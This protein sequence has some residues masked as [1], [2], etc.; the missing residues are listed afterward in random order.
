MKREREEDRGLARI[1]K[2]QKSA[3]PEP[4]ATPNIPVAPPP[5]AVN[6]NN[7]HLPL[8]LGGV[9][10]C[11]VDP[12]TR[13][14]NTTHPDKTMREL[15]I[16]NTTEACDSNVLK[17]F[18]NAAMTRVGLTLPN[19]PQFNNGQPICVVRCAPKFAFAQARSEVEAA[20][21]LNLTNIPFMGQ[22]LKITRPSK[23][24]GVK[25]KHGTWQELTGV[26]DANAP[27]PVSL[28]FTSD[29]RNGPKKIITDPND[30]VHREL[31]VGNTSDGMSDDE[32]RQFLNQT[33][34]QV[35][36]NYEGVKEPIVK[37][38]VCGK[39]AFIEAATE[40]DAALAMNLNGVPF[41]D[42]ELKF[43][44]PKNYPGRLTK[45]GSWNEI[46]EKVMSGEIVTGGPP[47]KIEY[48]DG[49][50]PPTHALGDNT[51]TPTAPATLPTRVLVLTNMLDI[52]TDLVDDNEY[53]DLLLDIK[54]ECNT[55]GDLTE[56]IIPRI[57]EPG[58]GL[59][60]LQYKLAEHAQKAKGEL[61]GRVFSGKT[62]GCKF[63]SEDK[64]A[65]K[66]L[67]DATD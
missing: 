5:P 49:H 45:H 27:A 13:Q 21:L 54:E 34:I 31:F 3:P 56:C 7:P 48:Q 9:G 33:L 35:N 26:P 64:F 43:S 60:F 11:P 15:F 10:M 52:D 40:Q 8:A 55:F 44:R 51:A 47:P 6:P 20:N 18:L 46:L 42:M 62:V 4:S 29:D 25:T 23:Y 1:L 65:A 67:A 16:G 17:A 12:A 57:G 53:A 59:V 30:K 58:V 66:D 36:L 2:Q 38:R 24:N 50:P 32:L 41:K 22:Y 37:C 39:F 14:L 19:F 63:Y 28:A 61:E